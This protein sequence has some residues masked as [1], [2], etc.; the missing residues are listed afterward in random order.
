MPAS[1]Q[2]L[3]VKVQRIQLHSIPEATRTR[4]TILGAVLGAWKGSSNL[5]GFEG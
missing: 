5:L 2:N 3:L 4:S 1:V